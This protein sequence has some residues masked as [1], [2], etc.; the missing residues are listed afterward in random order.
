MLL[1]ICILS[2]QTFVVLAQEEQSFIETLK[3]QPLLQQVF[4]NVHYEICT[5]MAYNQIGISI[6][7]EFNANKEDIERM[8]EIRNY[9]FKRELMIHRTDTTPSRIALEMG[10]LSSEMHNNMTNFSI[11]LDKYGQLCKEISEDP[12]KRII[13]WTTKKLDG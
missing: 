10:R 9:L 2:G 8:K 11:L 6:L 1:F 4:N 5:C 12:E 7:E 3:D 13:Y